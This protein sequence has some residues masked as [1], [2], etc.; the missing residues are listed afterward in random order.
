MH[1]K[2]RLRK[3][4]PHMSEQDLQAFYGHFLA[5][6]E[7]TKPEWKRFVDNGELLRT[8]ISARWPGWE[9][10]NQINLAEFYKKFGFKIQVIIWVKSMI[11]FDAFKSH[12][13]NDFFAN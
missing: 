2:L 8:N 11:Q 3:F 1:S 7:M 6:E 13:Q 12:Q 5:L 10:L 9:E 4:Y